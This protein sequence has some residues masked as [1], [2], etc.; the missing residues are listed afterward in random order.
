[1]NIFQVT[2]EGTTPVTVA[3]H[4]EAKKSIAGQ[5]EPK[6]IPFRA[7]HPFLFFVTC[8]PQK[9]HYHI[10]FMGTMRGQSTPLPSIEQ[11]Q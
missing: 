4:A 8:R 7:D 3:K 11:Y 2:E 6:S 1:M 10:V 9:Y 5:M